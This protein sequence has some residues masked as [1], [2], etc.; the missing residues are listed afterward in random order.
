MNKNNNNTNSENNNFGGSQF[1]H[2]PNYGK[3]KVRYQKNGRAYVI[4]KG[5]KIKL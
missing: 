4:V 5:N 1:I 3:R 2:V